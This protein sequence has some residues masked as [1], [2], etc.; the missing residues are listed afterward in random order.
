[1]AFKTLPTRR[2]PL[3]LATLAASIA[4]RRAETGVTDVPR[5]AGTRRTASKAALFDEIERLGKRW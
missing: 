4:R 2:E 3:T 1:M 5:N